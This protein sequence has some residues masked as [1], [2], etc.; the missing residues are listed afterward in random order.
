MTRLLIRYARTLRTV[1]SQR[2]QIQQL[3]DEAAQTQLTL[4]LLRRAIGDEREELRRA[5]EASPDESKRLWIKYHDRCEQL[6]RAN[7]AQRCSSCSSQTGPITAEP[8]S[9]WAS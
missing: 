2:R 1:R 3:L 9:R 8:R 7:Q 6:T 4:G 5:L